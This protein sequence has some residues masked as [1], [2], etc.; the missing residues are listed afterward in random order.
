[1]DGVPYAQRT[2]D[3]DPLAPLNIDYKFHMISQNYNR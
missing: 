2:V 3:V 1:M